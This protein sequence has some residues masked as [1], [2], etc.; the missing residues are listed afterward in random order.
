MAWLFCELDEEPLYPLF[1][2]HFQPSHKGLHAK[3]P[4]KTDINDGGRQLVKAPELALRS[5][6][7]LPFAGNMVAGPVIDHSIPLIIIAAS[8]TTRLLEAEVIHMQ[9]SEERRVGK[10]C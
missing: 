3:L 2:V 9:R 6:V 1:E 5:N 10:E 7:E 4:C 8:S